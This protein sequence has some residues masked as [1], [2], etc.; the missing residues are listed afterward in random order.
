MSYIRAVS[1]SG[2]LDT[3]PTV[4]IT[5]GQTRVFAGRLRL[6]ELDAFGSIDSL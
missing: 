4:S 5:T 2:S 6:R 3:L 1:Q